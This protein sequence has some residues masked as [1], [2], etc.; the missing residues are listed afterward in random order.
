MAFCPNPSVKNRNADSE[1]EVCGSSCRSLYIAVHL[2]ADDWADFQA[3]KSPAVSGKTEGG[4]ALDTAGSLPIGK[5]SHSWSALDSANSSSAN[6]TSEGI[7][8]P[9]SQSSSQKKVPAAAPPL[10][11][12][13]KAAVTFGAAAAVAPAAKPPAKPAS[14]AS[15]SFR[16]M[17]SSS[18]LLYTSPSPRD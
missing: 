11:P 5:K 9:S 2:M 13:A 10:A 1:V 4:T 6:T 16:S 17:F 8:P 18:C 15:S 7:S 3:F 14:T 12:L